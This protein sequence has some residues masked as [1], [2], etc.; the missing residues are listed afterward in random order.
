M[1]DMREK[2]ARATQLALAVLVLAGCGAATPLPSAAPSSL[3]GTAWRLVRFQGGDGTILTPDDRAKYTFQFGADGTL[4]ARIDC[5]RGR[6]TWTSSG[7][8][9]LTLGPLAL[10]RAMCPPG[11][12]DDRIV[13][14]LDFVRSYVIQGGHLFLSLLADAGIYELEPLG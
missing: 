13:R 8:S 5:N 10:T 14:D 3:G 2:A 6:G 7:P 1:K 9:Q 4:T 12:L 11:S